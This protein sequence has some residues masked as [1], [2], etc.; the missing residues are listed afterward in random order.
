LRVVVVGGQPAGHF[1]AA[2]SRELPRDNELVDNAML[3]SSASSL[4]R[5]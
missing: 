4:M 5:A 2:Q 1:P 3:I